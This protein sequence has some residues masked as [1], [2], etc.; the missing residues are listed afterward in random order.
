MNVTNSIFKNN[1]DSNEVGGAIFSY[2]QVNVSDSIFVGNSAT[3]GAAIYINNAVVNNITNSS[4]ISN[5]LTGNGGVV[6]KQNGTL[7]LEDVY[8]ANNTAGN[9]VFDAYGTV[10]FYGDNIFKDNSG[11]DLFLRSS[12]ATNKNGIANFKTAS[13]TFMSGGITGANSGGNSGVLNLE[14]NAV[15]SVGNTINNNTLNMQGGTLNLIGYN[16]TQKD[17]AANVTATSGDT[18]TYGSLNLVGLTTDAA[19]G[20]LINAQNGAIQANI[21]GD[22]TLGS[23]LTTRLDVNLAGSDQDTR[24]DRYSATSIADSDTNIVI[25]SLIATS[26]T[27]NKYTKA[28]VANDVLANR[29]TL[30]SAVLTATNASG[31][32]GTY[33][34]KYMILDG[35]GYLV[36][37]N[38]ARNLVT[39][40]RNEYGFEADTRTYTLI[41]DESIAY[42]IAHLG[43]T[44]I[45][46]TAS[47][48]AM[49]GTSFTVEGSGYSIS[50]DNKGGITVASGQ[51]LNIQ[52]VGMNSVGALIGDGWHGFNNTTG[53]SVV[54][55][56]GTTNINHSIFT[57]N[58]SSISG[59]AVYNTGTLTID[60]SRFVGNTSKV[61]NSLGTGGG[62]VYTNN[63]TTITES[64]FE[65]NYSNSY[66]G[67]IRI[68]GGT[69]NITD[70]NFIGN[71]AP[72]DGGVM[73]I[74]PGTVNITAQNEN[75]YFTNNITGADGGA[76]SSSG[77]STLNLK[78]LGG[79]IIFSGNKSGAT[80]TRNSTTGEITTSGGSANDIKNGAKLNLIAAEGYKIDLEGSIT[81][82][83]GITGNLTIGG[84]F[85]PSGSNDSQTATGTVNFGSTL[86]QKTIT[87]NSG[88]VNAT[89]AWT[90]KEST[91]INGADTVVDL[92][93]NITS[94]VITMNNG[95][96]TV[97]GNI[98]AATST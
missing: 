61:S 45:D 70:T 92:N 86:K 21:L 9:T 5:A 19:T 96:F 29:M 81:D 27:D 11:Y 84:S 22:V 20:S 83:S 3:N 39:S 44:S 60:N 12:S 15:L 51:T 23:D 97:N 82:E 76:I 28:L 10:N 91:K 57:D 63:N 66:G 93:S 88:T 48:G 69:T 64:V 59:G 35:K 34:A 49:Q 13:D 68:N 77:T 7:N 95:T 67:A 38:G 52:N 1:T 53:G 94:P 30:S 40:A 79:D 75:V 25:S 33:N 55:N 80:V 26:D 4:F 78:A 18:I 43:D 8:F 73:N 37:D 14:N 72:N 90:L 6:T 50:G 41:Q 24:A 98:S 89:G 74:K 47:I 46:N 62:A 87:V 42:D 2:G 36:F 54:N 16:K 31:V 71:V 17:L 58:Q 56:S 85:T 32:T 65:N